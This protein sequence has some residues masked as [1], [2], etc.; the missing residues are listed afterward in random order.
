MQ[1]SSCCNCPHIVTTSVPGFWHRGGSQEQQ[2]IA[3]LAMGCCNSNSHEILL[4]ELQPL[5]EEY[6]L[7]R[8]KVGHLS[9]PESSLYFSFLPS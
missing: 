4:Q 3:M 5:T 6:M 9:S 7:E 2:Q 1:V 8:F